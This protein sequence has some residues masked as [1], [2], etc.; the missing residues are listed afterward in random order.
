MF[1]AVVS[2]LLEMPAPHA[3][4]PGLEFSFL[5]RFQLPAKV[6]PGR[7]HT[8]AAVVGSCWSPGLSFQFLAPPC[9]LQ[10]FSRVSQQMAHLAF[11]VNLNKY[12]KIKEKYEII[13]LA[14][15]SPGLLG[16]VALRGIFLLHIF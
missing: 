7:Q 12:I 6:P 5:S 1:G 14:V 2:M 9:L 4:V 10:M 16:P 8:R 13:S 11:Q 15:C 3:G